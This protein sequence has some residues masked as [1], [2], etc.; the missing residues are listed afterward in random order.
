MMSE[1]S[2]SFKNHFLIAM[3]NLSDADF[4]QSVTYICEHG[5]QGTMGLIINH[6][7]DLSME[8]LFDH[9]DMPIGDMADLS[10]PVYTGGPVQKERGFILHDR[11]SES[12]WESTLLV[13]DEVALT[14]SKDILEDIALGQGPEHFI[15]AL[16]YAAW[17]P[18]QLEKEI[19]ENNWL[20]VEADSHLMF[21]TEWSQRWR[22]STESLGVDL[23]LISQDAGHG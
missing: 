22:F 17:G 4:E 18:G 14:A 6:P 9:L 23:H 20:N 7:I 13:S 12:K 15:I 2:Y 21:Q 11:T 1:S 19:I 5:P 8:S 10:R 16:G 3:P